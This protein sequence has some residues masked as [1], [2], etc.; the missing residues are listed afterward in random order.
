VGEFAAGK[1][2]ISSIDIVLVRNDIT[3][4]YLVQRFGQ[5]NNRNLN[6]SG[7]VRGILIRCHLCA[8]EDFYAHIFYFSGKKSFIY[9]CIVAARK[10]GLTLNQYGL[11]KK[12]KKLSIKS[13]QEIFDILGIEYLEHKDRV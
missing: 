6:T 1:E 10:K 11:W 4:Q 5:D 3:V 7:Y 13:E 8:K 2:E 12:G 9:K